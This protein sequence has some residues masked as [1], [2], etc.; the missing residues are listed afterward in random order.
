[1]RRKSIVHPS[2]LSYEDLLTNAVGEIG[3]AQ[4]LIALVHF[5]PHSLMPLSMITV[6]F[7]TGRTNWWKVSKVYNET[8]TAPF[9]GKTKQK[10]SV[11]PNNISYLAQISFLS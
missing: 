3:R 5:L 8:G 1:M 6:G 11:S 2:F 4:I 10:T 7:S 9:Y